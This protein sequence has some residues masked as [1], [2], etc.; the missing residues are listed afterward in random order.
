MAH[1]WQTAVG[2]LNQLRQIVH[3]LRGWPTPLGCAIND[4]SGK[5]GGRCVS[6]VTSTSY[7]GFDTVGLQVTEF[8]L[9]Q[10]AMRRA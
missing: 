4:A 10:Q 5:L 6:T 8:A 1:G 9:A 7:G 3:S 2:T